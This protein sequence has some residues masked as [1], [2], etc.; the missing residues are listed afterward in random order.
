LYDTQQQLCEDVVRALGGTAAYNPLWERLRIPVAVHNLG[1]C[2]MAD[3]RDGGVTDSNGEVFGHPNLYVFDGGCLPSATGVNPSHTIAAVAER[4]VEAAIRKLTGNASWVAPERKLAVPVTEPLD[5]VSI[6]LSGTPAVQTPGVGLTFTETMR[7]YLHRGHWPP[8]D[9]RGA[10]EAGRRAGTTASFTLDVT[11]SFLT[12]FIADDAHQLTAEGIVRVD[13][14]TGPRGA[15]VGNG[16]LNLLVPG[17]SPASR[18]MLYLLPFFGADGAPYLLDGYTDVR[19]HGGFDI[20]GATTTLYTYLRRGHTPDGEVLATGILY[21]PPLSY[22]RQLATARV[23]GTSNPLRQ[24]EALVRFGQLFVGSLFRV[25]VAP[26]L[27]FFPRTA[28]GSDGQELISTRQA[29]ADPG[30]R[31]DQSGVPGR[32][33]A[34]VAGR[35][36]PDLRPR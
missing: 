16:V 19:D 3:D 36:G 35:G 30:R 12:E 20:W 9:F 1:G 21:H 17:D 7:G 18:R 23:T 25:F 31:R 10:A 22:L 6:P 27:P 11:S 34:G 14:V 8:A 4:N 5:T 33:P 26:R 13:G 24:A 32:R 28:G 2:V 29:V 15:R